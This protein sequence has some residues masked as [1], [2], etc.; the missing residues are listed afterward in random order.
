M[1]RGDSLIRAPDVLR[2]QLVEVGLGDTNLA[3]ASTGGECSLDDRVND[4]VGIDAIGQAESPFIGLAFERRAELFEELRRRWARCERD[5]D[6]GRKAESD[7]ELADG[8]RGRERAAMKDADSIG[9]I[10][11]VGED[12]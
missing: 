5:V 3:N 10:L 6:L 12:V 2:E 1:S 11:H 9:D 7:D 8:S 4:S